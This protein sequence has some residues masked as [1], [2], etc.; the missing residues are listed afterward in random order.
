MP[1]VPSRLAV[2][3]AAVLCTVPLLTGCRDGGEPAGGSS[4]TTTASTE[5]APPATSPPTPD[6]AAPTGPPT[7]TGAF[8]GVRDERIGPP[9]NGRPVRDALVEGA[10][11]NEILDPATDPPAHVILAADCGGPHDAEVFL[12]IDLP[13]PPGTPFPGDEAADRE[14]YAACLAPFEGYVGRPYATSGL[15]VSLLRPVG[16][17]WFLGDRAVACSV[18]DDRLIPLVGSVRGSGR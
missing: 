11:Y 17:S 2:A 10:C 4:A 6:T 12:R 15:R 13:A 18:Y 14:A 3:L 1:R 9:G 8:G 7:A 5:A 16:S